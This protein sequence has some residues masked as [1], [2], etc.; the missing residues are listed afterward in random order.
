VKRSGESK[1]SLCLDRVGNPS[2]GR[3]LDFWRCFGLR[4][5]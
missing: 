5:W 4:V 1:K 2:S 3:V